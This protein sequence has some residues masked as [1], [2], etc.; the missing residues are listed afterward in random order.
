[1]SH[2]PGYIDKSLEKIVGLQTDAPLK[3]AIMPF[4]GI[5]MVKGSCKVYRRELKPEVEQIFTEYRKTHNQGVFDVYTPDILRCRK[6]GVITGLPDAYGRGRIIGDYRRMALYGAD[7][8]MKDKFNQFTSLQDKLERGEDIQATIQLR[9]EIAE[10]HRALGKMK[11]MAASYGY[12]ISGPA[13]NAHEAVQWTYF[14]YLA[15]VKS[16]NGAAMSFGRVSTF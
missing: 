4:G 14:A 3:R 2:A 6:S 5:N 8:L 16:Q 9:E 11:E 1:T 12:D 7:F 15:A 13:T 10:Q